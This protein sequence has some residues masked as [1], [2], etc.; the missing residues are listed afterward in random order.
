[1]VFYDV[2]GRSR[3]TLREL[4]H[5]AGY[6][7]S[8][9]VRIGNDAVGQLQHDVYGSAI[10][11]AATLVRCGGRLARDERRLLV[12]YGR[13]VCAAWREVD[14]GIWEI[15]GAR[16]HYVHSKLMCWSALDVLLGLDAGGH[17]QVPRAVFTAERDAIRAAIET[18]GFVASGDGAGSYVGAFG[19]DWVDA[20]LLVMA[21]LGFHDALD[22]RMVGTAERIWRELG[23]GGLLLR[24]L[25]EVDGLGSREG[26]FGICAFWAVELLV[27]QGRGEEAEALFEA[28]GGAGERRGAVGG[29]VR[30]GDWGGVGERAA[31]V[32]ACRADFGGAG[33]AG[34]ARM[35]S[36]LVLLQRLGENLDAVLLWALVATAVMTTVLQGSQ[37]PGVVAA[38][39]AVP[40][41]DAGDGG[42]EPGGAGGVAVLF[43]GGVGVRGG[44]FFRVCECRGGDVVDWGDAWGFARAFSAGVAADDGAAAPAD[45]E[46]V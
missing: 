46:R 1:M 34:G 44:V 25:P 41:R 39:L 36:S 31:G 4:G 33:V 2:H 8:S 43:V 35:S 20:S 29:G 23:R 22:P 5:L 6:R 21:R 38:E 37:G 11:A 12:R 15:P 10:A 13:R 16:R 28:G 40:V 30:P 9:P 26:A 14:S 45:R 24:Y 27:L 18:R 17:L 42:P 7:G 3:S 19:E 32:H